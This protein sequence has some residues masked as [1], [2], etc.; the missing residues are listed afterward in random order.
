MEPAHTRTQIERPER[1]AADVGRCLAEARAYFA[2]PAER[3]VG[4]VLREGA[5]VDQLDVQPVRGQPRHLGDAVSAPEEE[6]EL[7]TR[8]VG[9]L[10]LVEP[11]RSTSTSARARRTG[12]RRRR[13]S[14]GRS[15]VPRG[16]RAP[17]SD[18]ARPGLDDLG[19]DG[20]VLVARVNRPP[21][22]LCEGADV[23]RARR[24][25]QARGLRPAGG[26]RRRARRA[27]RRRAPAGSA[28]TSAAR[29]TRPGRARSSA[30]RA[31]IRRS[32]RAGGSSASRS[33]GSRRSI[34]RSGTTTWSPRFARAHPY[35]EP[36]FDIY[37]LL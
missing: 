20:N 25:P 10:E 4:A 26:A 18:A 28:T 8:V 19:M 32:A 30:A 27:V 14:L 13:C 12:A 24:Q 9:P 11:G 17:S 31:R 35:E 1:L 15:R 36:A 21:R 3:A 33:S 37:P 5:D 2:K 29:G 22:R 23:E 34:P 16:E 7:R 6:D